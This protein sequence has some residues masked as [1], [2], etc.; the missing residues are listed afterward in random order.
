M[1]KTDKKTLPPE[2]LE[3]LVTRAD[4][5]KDRILEIIK[6]KCPEGDETA[7]VNLNDILVAYYEEHNEVLKRTLVQN[8]VG[9]LIAEESVQALEGKR[10]LYYP[11]Y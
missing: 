3:E 1:G 8:K 9:K 11:V 2:L 6:A 4:E 10:G 7:V 5:K